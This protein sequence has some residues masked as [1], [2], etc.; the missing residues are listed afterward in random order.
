MQTVTPYKISFTLPCG[1][2]DSISCNFTQRVVE[3][4]RSPVSKRPR[5]IGVDMLFAPTYLSR[6]TRTFIGNT[7]NVKIGH[8]GC[9]H[10]GRYN[11]SS[12]TTVPVPLDLWTVPSPPS[13]SGGFELASVYDL[14][15]RIKNQKLNLAMV[16]A[17][18]GQTVNM[19][20]TVATQ[21]VSMYRNVKAGKLGVPVSALQRHLHSQ[22]ARANL[23]KR[24]GSKA[25]ANY[26][27]TYTYGIKPLLNDLKGALEALKEARISRPLVRTVRV[28]KEQITETAT[29]LYYGTTKIGPV[30]S[31]ET[32]TTYY[33]AVVQYQVGSSQDFGFGN[34]LSLG[35]EV[36]PYSFV[37]DMV[38]DIGDYLA[39][40]DALSG[41][42]R[43]TTYSVTKGEVTVQWPGGSV[44][45][46]KTY[47][48]TPL[49]PLS[50]SPP[51][52]TWDPS[53]SWKR[54]VSLTALLRQRL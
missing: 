18:Y 41:T 27:L 14:Y 11:V 12:R 9:W 40:L 37:L 4:G 8:E 24:F 31:S 45:T 13:I 49:G 44:G 21:L 16:M 46:S 22:R 2:A 20:S 38:I 52:P 28:K 7:V 10:G 42:I 34:L 39:S 32:K 17:E 33:C 1:A 48:R 53:L 5:P 25:A 6:W 51:L 30:I 19:F 54:V 29:D 26:W 36:I 15:A 50:R 3:T 47:V 23:K 43:N 35:W